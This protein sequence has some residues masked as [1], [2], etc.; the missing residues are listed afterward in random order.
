MR[1]CC[2]TFLSLVGLKANVQRLQPHSKGR[3]IRN[4]T[5]GA[6]VYVHWY[7]ECGRLDSK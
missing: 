3:A 7:S 1:G 6:R 5:E 2:I 4:K